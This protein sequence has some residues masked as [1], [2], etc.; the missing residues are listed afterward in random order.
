MSRT[1]RCEE[2]GI[3]DI[4]S[5]V[6]S[7]S[8]PSGALS[9]SPSRESRTSIPLCFPFSPETT[10]YECCN[11][12]RVTDWKVTRERRAVVRELHHSE[13]CTRRPRGNYTN[14]TRLIKGPG[15]V[16]RA[17]GSDVLSVLG[18]ASYLETR[19]ARIFE[20]NGENAARSLRNSILRGY[21]RANAVQPSIRLPMPRSSMNDR[22]LLE[23]PLHF[24][25]GC[26]LDRGIYS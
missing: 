26:N 3:S 5:P 1:C 10:P 22:I 21:G 24:V 19:G 13:E 14:R 4:L 6:K 9:V 11:R 18:A 17:P 23:F 12:R 25:P 16:Q 2:S 7:S 8:R 20:N 15:R